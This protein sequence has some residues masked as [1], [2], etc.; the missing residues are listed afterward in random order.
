MSRES[1]CDMGEKV[2]DHATIWDPI[3]IS[4]VTATSIKHGKI[5]DAVASKINPIIVGPT[6]A[7]QYPML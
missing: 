2:A 1:L 4:T 7:T 6:A 5:H 3:I